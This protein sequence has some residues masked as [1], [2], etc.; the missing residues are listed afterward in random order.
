MLLEIVYYMAI[1][2][3]KNLIYVLIKTNAIALYNGNVKIVYVHIS[4]NRIS[5][6]YIIYTAILML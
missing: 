1:C 2:M 6:V 4:I 5:C 3:N